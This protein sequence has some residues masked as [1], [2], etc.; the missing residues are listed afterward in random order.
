MFTCKT[1]LIFLAGALFF[2]ALSHFALPYYFQLPLTVNGFTLTNELNMIIAWV[3][4]AV[5]VAFLFAAKR[6]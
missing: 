1:V 2:H 4:L 6:C 3:S 5:S